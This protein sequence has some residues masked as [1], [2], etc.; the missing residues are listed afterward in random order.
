[1]KRLFVMAVLLLGVVSFY[2]CGSGGGG[3]SGLPVPADSGDPGGGTPQPGNTQL[4][5][6]EL[7][8]SKYSVASNGSD[9][10]TFTVF[11]KDG[12]NVALPGASISITATST[13]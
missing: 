13:T 1:M 2:G 12:S 9:S 6:I 7:T 5:S 4:A 11:A 8:A 3:D 10:T